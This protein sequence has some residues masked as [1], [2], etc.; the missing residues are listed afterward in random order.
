MH[1]SKTAFLFLSLSAVCI[2]SIFW[3]LYDFFV[4]NPRPV[5]AVS[6]EII[7]EYEV[8]DLVDSALKAEIIIPQ[9]NFTS[10]ISSPFRSQEFDPAR[11]PPRT[12]AQTAA[13]PQRVSLRLKGLM[14]NPPLVIVE[15]ESGE[16]HIKAQGDNV[17]GAL[18]VSIGSASAVFKDS[19]GTYELMVEENR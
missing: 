3:I 7:S 16:T 8:F 13:A 18:I 12:I 10:E 14:R 6:A 19:S 4:I 15:D 9:A 2:V 1:S 5:A 11:L 17:R